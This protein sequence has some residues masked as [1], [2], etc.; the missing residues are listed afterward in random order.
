[1]LG[2]FKRRREREK[3]ERVGELMSARTVENVYILGVILYFSG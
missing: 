3:D 2:A 1:M